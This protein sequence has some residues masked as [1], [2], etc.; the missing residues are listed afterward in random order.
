MM[1]T[2]RLTVISAPADSPLTGQNLDISIAGS[3]LGRGGSNAIV[4]PDHER[5]VSTRHASIRHDLGQ[6][7]LTDHST[8]G[9]FLNESPTPIGPEKSVPL[10]NG[11]I[12]GMGKYRMKVSLQ[13][14]AA[15]APVPSGP[16][17]LD[18]LGIV[19]THPSQPEPVSADAGLDDFDKWLEP[20]S[21]PPAQQQPLWG[22]SNVEHA[23]SGGFDDISDPLAAIEKAQ[24]SDDLFASSP[25]SLDD[26]PDWWKGSQGDN[27]APLNQ[28]F[29][30]P[31]PVVPEP[32]PAPIAPPVA[33][34]FT[35]ATPSFTSEATPVP[36]VDDAGNLDALLGLDSSPTP[37]QTFASEATPV[38][39]ANW[40]DMPPAV[41]PA[42]VPVPEPTPVPKAAPVPPAAVAAMPVAAA[43]ASQAPAYPAD[44]GALLAQLL[45]LGQITPE[46]LQALPGEVTDVL[47]ETIARLVEMLRAR[48]SIKNE[49]RIDRTMIKPMEN[50]PL[51]FALTE[52][53]ALR[54]LFGERSGAYMSGRRAVEEAFSDIEQH[55]VALLAGM[56]S[57]YEKMLEKFSPDA[58]EQQFGDAVQVGL[59]GNKKSR[60]W[61]AYGE[62]F[63]KLRQDPEASFNKLFGNAFANAYEEQVNTI[64][65]SK[66]DPSR[67]R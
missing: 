63:D 67:S 37:A 46:Q 35:A 28:A 45:D 33:P 2:L 32:T 3:T 62:Y 23:V 12:I 55:Q 20:Q 15:P 22:I 44:T 19:S 43:S 49:L 57:A 4:L 34:A 29:T 42:A 27:A 7:V 5:I 51:K 41:N 56:R 36:V 39:P 18:D 26:D 58:L 13:Q 52:K 50:N 38:P 21:T 8:N 64:K 60:L 54:Y 1:T 14:P 24:Q 30:A 17:F 48:S 59:L 65:G 66:R 53:D 11:D 47:R 40:R 6:F 16:A 61:D 31:R 25:A 9:T 10:Q